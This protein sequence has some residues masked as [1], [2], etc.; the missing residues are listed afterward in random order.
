MLIF[1]TLDILKGTSLAVSTSHRGRSLQTNFVYSLRKFLDAFRETGNTIF[2]QETLP[3]DTVL[4]AQGGVDFLNDMCSFFFF[5]LNLWLFIKRKIFL[6]E[7]I[8]NFNLT[9]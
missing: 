7:K 2:N 8:N 6:R 5:L 4:H 9:R 3:E 1:A